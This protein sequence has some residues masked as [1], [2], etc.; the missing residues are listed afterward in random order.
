MRLRAHPNVI[1]LAEQR[2]AREHQSEPV[3]LFV[4]WSA[5]PAVPSHPAAQ[6]LLAGLMEGVGE[7]TKDEAMAD[8]GKRLAEAAQ[9]GR[10]V[11]PGRRW[12]ANAILASLGL[13][14]RWRA[15]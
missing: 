1:S 11:A 5:A 9:K 15:F 7:R 8:A 14:K 2:G 13:G 10:A 6:A 4:D 12:L 3:V